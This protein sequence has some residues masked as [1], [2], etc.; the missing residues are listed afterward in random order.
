MGSNQPDLV[1]FVEGKVKL[2]EAVNAEAS[3]FAAATGHAQRVTGMGV[4][5]A[6]DTKESAER[7]AASEKD[8]E[9]ED[10]RVW[11]SLTD[12]NK[13]AAKFAAQGRVM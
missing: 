6:V 9:A 3:R 10:L 2:A 5:A 12:G 8:Q 13:D 4:A 11:E 7:R 1:S